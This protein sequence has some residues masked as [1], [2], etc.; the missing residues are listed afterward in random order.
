MLLVGKPVS[1]LILQ[2]IHLS[3]EGRDC[4]HSQAHET[5]RLR[6]VNL[7][8]HESGEEG[9]IAFGARHEFFP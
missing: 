5:V 3:L 6:A 4:L 7:L 8:Q 2:K 9:C 1:R